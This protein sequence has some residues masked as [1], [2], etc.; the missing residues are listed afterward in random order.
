[1]AAAQ[2]AAAAVAAAQKAVKAQPVGTFEEGT[3]KSRKTAYGAADLPFEA[4]LVELEA[5]LARP[6]AAPA[7]ALA[8]TPGPRHLW[9]S[10]WAAKGPLD[11]PCFEATPSL[12]QMRSTILE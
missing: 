4:E 12:N 1:M 5:L 8:A 7:S 11:G 6:A 2:K 10:G 9:G 3:H